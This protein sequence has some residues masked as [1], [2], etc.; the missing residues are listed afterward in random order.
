[1]DF[2]CEE[3]LLEASSCFADR[4]EFE[5]RKRYCARARAAGAA[6]SGSNTPSS[7]CSALP[8]AEE[9]GGFGGGPVET[10][11]VM[12]AFGRAL[13]LE[14]YLRH[15]R[16]RRRLPS[17]RRQRRAA[18]RTAAEDRRR[19]ALLSP[20]PMPSGSRATISPTSRP[21]R[22]ATAAA[23]CS[24][25]PRALVLHGDAADKFIVIGAR[26]RASGATATASALFL[27]DANGRGVSRARLSDGGRPARRR[28]HAART[29]ASAPTP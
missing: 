22:G 25:A 26:F 6:T 5:T 2:A 27:V 21:R 7:A 24:T 15:R 9:H 19:R 10:M 14:P 11:I 8:F 1:M 13:A 4:Y 18:R 29:C 20:S 3:Q 12:E 23:T 28:S 16:A 17:A